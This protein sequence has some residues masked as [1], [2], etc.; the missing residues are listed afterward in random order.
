MK[1]RPDVG[2]WRR[3]PARPY[4]LGHRGARHNLPENTMAAFAGALAEGADGVELDVRLTADREVVVIHDATLER[5]TAGRD[6]RAVANLTASELARVDV[7][8][9]QAPPLL[10]EVLDW[11]LLTRARVNVEIKHDAKA[12]RDLVDRVAEL[13]RSEPRLSHQL[14]CSCFHPGVVL[15][16]SKLV[17]ELPVAW[18]VHARSR[19]LSSAPG[20]RLIGASGVH[21]HREL[22]SAARMI[23]WRKAGGFV[24]VWTV[25]DPVEA[26]RLGQLGVDALITDTPGSVLRAF[27]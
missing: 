12:T 6:R 21:P 14:L 27:A 8:A 22:V 7:G 3:A 4:V 9:G 20:L 23:G 11:A 18:L 16:L 26:A 2:H 15:R 25:N 24:N 10:R 1:A 17:P 19:I 13:V 5:V